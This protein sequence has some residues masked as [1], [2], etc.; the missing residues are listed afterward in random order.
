MGLAPNCSADIT[1][2]KDGSSTAIKCNV[3]EDLH[4]SCSLVWRLSQST[5]LPTTQRPQS[6]S[7][8]V[9]AKARITKGEGLPSY[10]S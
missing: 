4:V 9:L 6:A 10:K 5:T 8:C 1:L 7:D 2:P 3:C